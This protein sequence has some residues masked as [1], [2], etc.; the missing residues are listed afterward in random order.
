MTD[1][2]LTGQLGAV[3]APLRRELDVALQPLILQIRQNARLRY[4][5]IAV[6]I[7][8]WGQAIL[9][10]QDAVTAEVRRLTQRREELARLE[11]FAADTEWP[12]RAQDSDRLRASLEGRLWPIETE[13]LVRAEFQEWLMTNARK[14]GIGRPTVRA[15]RTDS[16]GNQSGFRAISATLSGDF[17]PEG[18]QSFLGTV[19]NDKRLIVIQSMRIQRNP[20]PRIDL[21]LAIYGVPPS[22]PGAPK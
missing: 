11:R 5:L 19:A 13:G 21:V 3:L 7:I 20:L 15:E 10:V 22:A 6:F 16:E 4:A 9:L 8:L 2:S 12:K 18:L 17:T 14:A 1:Q